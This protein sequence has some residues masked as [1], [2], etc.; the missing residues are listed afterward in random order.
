MPVAYLPQPP[1]KSVSPVKTN[2][3]EEPS[4]LHK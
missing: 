1:I 2:F 3:S 4:S